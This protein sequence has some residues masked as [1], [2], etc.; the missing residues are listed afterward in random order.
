MSPD[1]RWIAY[2]GYDDKRFTSHVSSLYLMDKSGG[3]KRAWAGALNDS[4]SSVTWAADNSGV[5]FQRPR[6]GQHVDLLRAR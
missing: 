5:Y 2:T 3:P 6:A 4:P 1:G